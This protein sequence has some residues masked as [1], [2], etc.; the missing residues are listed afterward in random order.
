M[1]TVQFSQVVSPVVLSMQ[2]RTQVL[3]RA[4]AVRVDVDG[5]RLLQLVEKDTKRKEGTEKKGEEKKKD[6]GPKMVAVGASMHTPSPTNG[7]ASQKSKSQN[8]KEKKASDDN[9]VKEVPLSVRLLKSKL[10]DIMALHLDKPDVQLLSYVLLPMQLF[11]MCHQ[12]MHMHESSLVC[13]YPKSSYQP[14]F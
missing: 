4:D 9:S 14:C 12:S 7:V 1:H 10:A 3:K 6:N 2:L 8:Q 11:F 13:D 5:E